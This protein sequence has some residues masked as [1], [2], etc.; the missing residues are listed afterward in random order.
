M[1]RH[2]RGTQGKRNWV[3]L[4]VGGLWGVGLWLSPTSARDFTFAHLS[5]THV[6]NPGSAEALAQV[7]RELGAKDP[8]P[9]FIL[10]TGNLTEFGTPRDWRDYSALVSASP[11]RVFSVLGS[12][13]VKW[14]GFGRQEF[15]RRFGPSQYW[16]DWQDCHFVGLNSTVLLRGEGHFGPAQ[17]EWLRRELVPVPPNTPLFLFFHHPPERIDDISE[18]LTLLAGRNVALFLVGHDRAPRFYRYQGYPVRV[19]GQT[20]ADI[21]GYDLV[22]VQDEVITISSYRRGQDTPREEFTVPLRPQPL[23]FVRVEQPL[24]YTTVPSPFPLVAKMENLAPSAEEPLALTAEYCVDGGPWYPLSVTDHRAEGEVNYLRWGGFFSGAHRLTVRFRQRRQVIGQQTISFYAELSGPVW[25]RWRRRLP[26]SVRTQPV[27]TTS[28]VYIGSNDGRLYALDAHTGEILWERATDG[29][30]LSSPVL[31]QEVIYF[32]SMDGMLYAVDAQWGRLRWRF[33]TGGPL[34]GPPTVAE[35]RVYIGSADGFLYAVQT[36]TGKEVWRYPAGG[37]VQAKPLLHR[38][39]LYFGSWNQTFH[40]VEAATGQR[41]WTQTIGRSRYYSPAAA[42]PV[43]LG[44]RVYVTAPDQKLYILEANTG[45]L[46]SEQTAQ[47]YDSLGRTADA[48]LVRAVDSHLYAYEPDG[49]VRWKTLLDWGWDHA[50]IMPFTA[51]D[52]IYTGSKPGWVYALTSDGVPLWKYRLTTGFMLSTVGVG[53]H[54]VVGGTL[55]GMV[56]ALEWEESEA[57]LQAAP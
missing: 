57:E 25:A 21:G 43:A 15:A 40:C 17:L 30:I 47:A 51:D 42:Y 44:D 54:L 5:D 11:V 22:R 10:H 31:A 24:P 32:G 53:D 33:A 50:A 38:G 8:R 28:T 9:A 52:L 48:V 36:E 41:V 7:L 45:R 29:P 4:V 16:F 37:M 2:Q 49:R 56:T 18:L 12:H 34:L 6:G 46:L 1:H 23:P 19:V 14:S 35:G 20:F 26:D 39:R 13:D 3:G 27:V 55:D